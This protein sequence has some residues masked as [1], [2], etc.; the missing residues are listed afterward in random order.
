MPPPVATLL[1][2]MAIEP[3]PDDVAPAPSDMS[4]WLL[5]LLPAPRARA[6]APVDWAP[7]PMAIPSPPL[8]RACVPLNPPATMPVELPMTM[9]PFVWPARLAVVALA[10]TAMSPRPH[11]VALDPIAEL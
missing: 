5:A 9:L 6:A 7:V 11:E 1:A 4:S 8:A 10:P 2:P 3:M